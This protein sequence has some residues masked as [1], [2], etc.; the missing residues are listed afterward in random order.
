MIKWFLNLV[1]N[2]EIGF[3]IPATTNTELS[4]LPNFVI[5]NHQTGLFKISVRLVE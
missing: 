4:L 1:L 3:R 2:I 5:C